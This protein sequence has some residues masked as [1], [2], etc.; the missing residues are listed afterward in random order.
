MHFESVERFSSRE[1]TSNT[2]P[3]FDKTCPAGDNEGSGESPRGKR[4]KEPSLVRALAMTFG[5]AIIVAFIFHLI[6]DI[7]TFIS[8]QLLK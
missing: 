4:V 6:L 5:R 8:P 7:L 1:Q 3:K 2:L